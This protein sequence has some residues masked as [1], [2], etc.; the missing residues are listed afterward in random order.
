MTVS[1]PEA[2]VIVLG[3]AL[4]AV[5]EAV[6]ELEPEF[7]AAVVC[8]FGPLCELEPQAASANALPSAAAVPAPQR[9]M[10]N[11]SISPRVGVS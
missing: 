4:V 9:R 6:E 7:A 5:L 1:A 11:K 2:S 8:V 3:P 10:D